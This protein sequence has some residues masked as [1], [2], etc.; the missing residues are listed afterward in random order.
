MLKRILVVTLMVV[1]VM[2]I[3][4]YADDGIC[5]SINGTA[6][7]F[8]DSKPFIDENGRTLVPF[9]AVLESFG[10]AVGWDSQNNT[11]VATKGAIVVKIPTGENY[12]LKNNEKIE[13]DAKAININGSIYLPIRAVLEAFDADVR[14]NADTMTV[15]VI[16]KSD[17]EINNVSSTVQFLNPV[18]EALIRDRLRLKD[19]EPITISELQSI[20]KFSC[21]DKNL[22]NISD[23]ANLTE[24]TDLDLQR[25][26][27]VDIKPLSK[28]KKITTLYLSDNKIN[29]INPLSSLENLSIIWLTNNEISDISPLAHCTNLESISMANNNV[30]DISALGS[31]AK[32][33]DLRADNNKITDISCITSWKYIEVFMIQNNQVAD[34]TPL[35]KHTEL[36]SIRVTG[37]VDKD[38]S[39][40][41]NLKKLQFTD[42]EF[43][44]TPPSK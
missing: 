42:F 6:V 19:N 3:T 37:N 12:V 21:T 32:L 39:K 26:Q 28:L 22:G 27:I 33:S 29:D 43:H 38:Y 35:S 5:V 30:I 11:A 34:L 17:E 20:T 24:L 41:N 2:G 25:C 10:A 16:T 18:I 1:C 8:T 15:E 14:W 31:L 13:N 7:E 44:V 9:R 36:E 40:F 4:A 23:L